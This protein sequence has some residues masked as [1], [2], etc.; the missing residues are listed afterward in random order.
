MNISRPTVSPNGLYI[1]FW[2]SDDT[3]KECYY[4][5]NNLRFRDYCL[6]NDT[7]FSNALTAQTS[8]CYDNLQID[9]VNP[10]NFKFADDRCTCIGGLDLFERVFTNVDL[11][12]PAEKALLLDNLPCLMIDC[13]ATRINFDPSNVGRLMTDKCKLPITI[14]SNI[15]RA[16]GAAA[17]GNISINQN[18]GSETAACDTTEDCPFGEL[19]ESGKCYI[20]CHDISDCKANGSTIFD[21][22]NGVCVPLGVTP[23]GSESLSLGAI[24]GIVVGVIVVIVIVA[25]LCW[26]YLVYKKKHP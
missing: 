7:I 6:T 22:F 13:T 24:I 4:P 5:Y 26:Y 23:P 12:P 14:C 25:V 16:E 10:L 2:A 20:S 21:C 18:C 17:I 1:T 3:L 11:L 15:I 19:C 9:P 8:Y